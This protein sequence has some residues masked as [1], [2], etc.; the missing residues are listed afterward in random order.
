MKTLLL[1]AAGAALAIAAIPAAAQ[2]NGIGVTEP[3]IAIAGS[4]ARATAYQQIN[5]QFQA[6]ITQLQ[7]QEQQ[8]DTLVR[9]FD[10]DGNGQLSEA[11][12]TAAQTNT[13]AVQQLN[14]LNQTIAQAQQP[15]VRARVYA[16]EQIAMQYSVAAQ[17]VIGEKQIQFILTP[18]SVVYA[19]EAADVTDEIVAAL[20]ARVPTVSITPPDGWQ[21]NRQSYSLY[22][23]VQDILV[24]AAIQQ[25]QAAGAQQTPATPAATPPASTTGQQPV[26]GR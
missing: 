4:Q 10:T 24:S 16:I 7:Q 14:Q 9:Q 22:E 8:R 15:I 3:A 17:Q 23:Q 11:E 25:Q 18:G 13:A 2:V 26:S 20:N 1:S 19:A 12:Q 5:A 21:V 6:Q